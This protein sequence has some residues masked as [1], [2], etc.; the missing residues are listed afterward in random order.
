MSGAGHKAKIS[1]SLGPDGPLLRAF[2]AD[3]RRQLERRCLK[4]AEEPRQHEAVA[5]GGDLA[6]L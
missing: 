4:S 5:E 6:V 2:P 3:G 1:R